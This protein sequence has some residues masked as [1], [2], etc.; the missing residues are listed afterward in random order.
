M[1]RSFKSKRYF[2]YNFLFHTN[3][4]N[5]FGKYYPQLSL[6]TE[7]T[8][9]HKLGHLMSDITIS[10]DINPIINFWNTHISQQISSNDLLLIDQ[11]V[12]PAWTSDISISSD[13]HHRTIF[14]WDVYNPNYCFL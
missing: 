7:Q 9:P 8:V 10:G 12:P 3:K 4:S 14:F 6:Y 2:F 1:S 13:T 5:I 11:T